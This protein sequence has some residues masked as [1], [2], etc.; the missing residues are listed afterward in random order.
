M[1]KDDGKLGQTLNHLLKL[2]EIRIDDCTHFYQHVH[3][4]SARRRLVP[5]KQ[6]RFGVLFGGLLAEKAHLIEQRG[7]SRGQPVGS[8]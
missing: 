7:F 5:G 6:E 2:S 4:V 3:V 8:G 1:T